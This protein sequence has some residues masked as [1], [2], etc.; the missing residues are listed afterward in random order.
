MRRQGLTEEQT[1]LAIQLYEAGHSYGA[2]AVRLNKAKSSVRA[3][4]LL[5]QGG[6]T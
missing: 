4:I 6:G 5:A 1:A 2:V 3:A